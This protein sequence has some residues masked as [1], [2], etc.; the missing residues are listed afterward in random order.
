MQFDNI[1]ELIGEDT[2][3]D[4]FRGRHINKKL[5]VDVPDGVYDHTSKNNL[6]WRMVF[7]DKF[8][9]YI[10]SSAWI[11]KGGPSDLPDIISKSAFGTFADYQ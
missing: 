10:I 8:M 4:F 5:L 6:Q 11:A 7:I 1:R 9:M 2:I 3:D